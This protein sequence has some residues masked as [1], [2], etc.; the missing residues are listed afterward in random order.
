MKN[1]EYHRAKTKQLLNDYHGCVEENLRLKEMNTK[2][3]QSKKSIEAKYEVISRKFQ[4]LLDINSNQAK[5]SKAMFGGDAN[6][7]KQ[8]NMAS[9]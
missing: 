9:E 8:A 6:R 7:S 5:S 2:L 4:Q 3:A 1:C